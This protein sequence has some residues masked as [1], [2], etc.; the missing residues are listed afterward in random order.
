MDPVSSMTV[1]L[2][3][4]YL[5]NFKSMDLRSIRTETLQR[6]LRILLQSAEAASDELDR[7][8]DL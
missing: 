4:D 7:R 3:A 8:L 5:L 1:R 6:I 2:L